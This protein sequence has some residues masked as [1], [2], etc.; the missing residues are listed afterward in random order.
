ML[1]VEAEVFNDLMLDNPALL[2]G[3]VRFLA[4]ELRSLLAEGYRT[5][6]LP[7]VTPDT[8]GHVTAPSRHPS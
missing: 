2:S 5:S 8:P 6:P 4:R 3:I 1:F 7:I